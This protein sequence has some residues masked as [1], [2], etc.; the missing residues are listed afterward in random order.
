MASNQNPEK[1]K[2]ETG[3]PGGGAGRRDEVG[4]SGVYP[5]SGPHP[6]GDAPIIP[7]PAFGQG[8]DGSAGYEESGRSEIW[9]SGGE[10]ELCRDIMSTE[11]VCCM[12]SDNLEAVARIMANRDVG[13]I[14]VVEDMH[15][16]KLIGVVTDRDLVTRA[17]AQGVD[18][19]IQAV[20]DC[21]TRDVA[22]CSPDDRIQKCIELMESKQVRR[23]PVVDNSGRIVGII[24]QA[25]IALRMRDVNNMAEI[26]REISK[27][28]ATHGASESAA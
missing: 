26:V 7:E 19:R 3:M 11:P 15:T 14:P 8:E 21:M 24:A 22:V 6:E 25:D 13:E 9:Y 2:R 18:C 10:P 17:V 1:D 23:M 4:S 12:A 28:N 20:K 5:M 16:K 27:P